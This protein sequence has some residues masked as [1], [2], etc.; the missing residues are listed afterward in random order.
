[1]DAIQNLTLGVGVPDTPTTFSSDRELKDLRSQ[2]QAVANLGGVAYF[3]GNYNKA[4]AL[5][6]ATEIL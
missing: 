4:I 2:T 3:Q 1:L 5:E 6:E